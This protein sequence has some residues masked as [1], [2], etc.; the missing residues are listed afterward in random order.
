MTIRTFTKDL[1]V[2]IIIALLMI[3]ATITRAYAQSASRIDLVIA[4]NGEVVLTWIGAPGYIT[5][6]SDATI[7]IGQ[8]VATDIIEVDSFATM[9]LKAETGTAGTYHDLVW[10]AMLHPSH[11]QAYY[12]GVVIDG[13]RFDF[14]G[15]VTGCT[16]TNYIPLSANI[17]RDGE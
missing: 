11:C 16:F 14:Y 3:L 7:I 13:I 4:Q 6:D 15:Q 9:Q 12:A 1:V 2:V 10:S 5:A 17:V 8:Y